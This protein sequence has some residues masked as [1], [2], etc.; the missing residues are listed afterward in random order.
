MK[1]GRFRHKKG[2]MKTYYGTLSPEGTFVNVIEDFDFCDIDYTGRQYELTELEYLPP[3]QPTKIVAVGLNYKNHAQEMQKK[4]PEEPLLFIKPSSSIIP[5]LGSIVMPAASKRVD[6]ESELAV[7]IGKT[8]KNVKKSDAKDFIFGYTC[9]NDVTARDLQAKDIQYT[10]AKGFDTFA[11]VGPYIETEI[12]NP[13]NLAIKGY[14]NAELKQSSNTSDLIF[15]PFEL[16][17]FVSGIMTLYPGDIISTGTPAG[18]GTLNHKD[19]F[20][21][22][23]ENIGTLKNFV[24]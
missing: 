6:Y 22:E 24:E 7:V 4:L 9:L 1:F 16:V 8:A 17:E 15:S 18:I 13:S 14:L 5:H 23:I 12:D 11:P 20:E 2:E 21:I 3:V 10:R 19:I